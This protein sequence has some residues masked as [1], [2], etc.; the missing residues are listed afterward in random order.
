VVVV[1]RDGAPV[2]TLRITA[3]NEA[4]G[5]T[6]SPASLAGDAQPRLSSYGN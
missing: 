3:K 2:A 5:K 1:R 4:L 6:Q